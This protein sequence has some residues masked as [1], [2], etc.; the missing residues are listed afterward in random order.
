MPLV[1]P[2]DFP[3][4]NQEIVGE[5][6]GIA[7]DHSMLS[8]TEARAATTNEGG[9]SLFDVSKFLP[10]GLQPYAKAF[11]VVITALITLVTSLVARYFDYELDPEVVLAIFTVIGAS[12]VWKTTNT[13]PGPVDPDEPPL[14]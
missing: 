13:P 6:D 7:Y 12:L 1:K 5:V 11:S 9:S 2:E 10:E 8:E 3:Y 4:G 14:V